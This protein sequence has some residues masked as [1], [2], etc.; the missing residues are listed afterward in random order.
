MGKRCE[1][2]GMPL[3]RDPQGGGSEADGSKSTRYCA[4]CYGDGA[5]LHPDVDAATFQAECLKAMHGNGMPKVVAWLLTRGIPKLP[6]WT[7]TRD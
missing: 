1:S 7:E 4:M 3:A 2:C 5:F 6:R